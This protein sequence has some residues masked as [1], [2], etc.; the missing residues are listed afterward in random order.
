[1][2]GLYLYDRIA[3]PSGE[4]TEKEIV[5]IPEARIDAA[6]VHG[7]GNGA[8]LGPTAVAMVVRLVNLAGDLCRNHQR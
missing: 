3:E 5:L 7:H 8:D 1:M 6:I 2:I 4:R